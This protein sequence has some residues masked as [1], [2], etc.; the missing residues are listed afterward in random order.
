[1]KKDKEYVIYCQFSAIGIRKIRASNLREAK[2]I[3]ES[4]ESVQFDE[5]IRL[6][7]PCIVDEILL[8]KIDETIEHHE[9]VEYKSWGAE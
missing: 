7:E 8:R 2:Q 5:I 4:D 6:T 9:N 3:A 1:M